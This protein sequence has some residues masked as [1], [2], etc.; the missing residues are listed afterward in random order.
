MKTTSRIL[1]FSFLVLTA[2]TYGCKKKVAPVSER[3]A[4]AW[5][6]RI[7]E[8]NGTSVYNKTGANNAKPGYSNFKLDLSTATVT[9]R[10]V[11]GSTTTFTGQWSV[12]NDNTL[13][14]TNLT[15]Q[16]TGTG[17]TIT[18]TINSLSDTELVIT[19]TST[20]LKTGTANNKY[21]LSNP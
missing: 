19:R 17:G 2:L 7:V 1:L 14:L 3:I 15:P 20:S 12:P 21:T 16:P 6:A 10:D 4:K 5:T 8:E 18:F 13:V 11:D 9:F